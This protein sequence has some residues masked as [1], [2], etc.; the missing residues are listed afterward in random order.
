MTFNAINTFVA[1]IPLLAP[2]LDLCR[3]R[4]RQAGRRAGGRDKVSREVH[5][6]QPHK[7]TTMGDYYS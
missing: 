5:R 6:R 2:L 1:V 7:S 4:T 3:P